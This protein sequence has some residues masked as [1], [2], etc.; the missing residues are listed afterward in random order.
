MLNRLP[1]SGIW[2]VWIRK[3]F[4]MLLIGV[5]IYF[6]IPQLER[7]YDNLLFLFGL[8]ASFSGLLLGFLDHAPGYTRNFKIVRSIFGISL[9]LLGLYWMNGAIHSKPSAIEWI[10]YTN[11]SIEQLQQDEEPVFIDFYADWCAPCKQLD[12]ITFRNP[13]V[14]EAAKHFNMVKVDCTSPNETV[15]AFMEEFRVSGLPTLVFVAKS[16]VEIDALREIG[17]IGP[18]KFIDSMNK[19][20]AA[21]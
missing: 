19:T 20:L 13:D 6:L 17:Y 2:M 11:Q 5:V 9:F 10:H 16:G 18:D 14:V 1:Q 12:R 8:T 7:I 21:P 4:G 3:L 15:K